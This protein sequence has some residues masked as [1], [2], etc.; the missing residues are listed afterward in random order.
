M[1][2][3]SVLSGRGLQIKNRKAKKKEHNSS[4]RQLANFL[5]TYTKQRMGDPLFGSLMD[6]FKK[7]KDEMNG[8]ALLMGTLTIVMQK[9]LCGMQNKYAKVCRWNGS[10]AAAV[11]FQNMHYTSLCIKMKPTALCFFFSMMIILYSSLKIE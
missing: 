8:Q 2:H 9:P 11:S 1:I 4:E 10:K 5:I 7:C 6:K 3:S